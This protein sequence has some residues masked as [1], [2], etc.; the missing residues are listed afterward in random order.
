MSNSKNRDGNTVDGAIAPAGAGTVQ[1]TIAAL[2]ALGI[3]V[4][5]MGPDAS[6]SELPGPSGNESV[7]LSALA[8]LTGA[9]DDAGNPLVFSTSVAPSDLTT[10]I[11]DA[12]TT[13][14]TRPIDIR[15]A[16]SGLPSGLSFAATPAVV[17]DVAPGGS[18]D[19]TNGTD[20]ERRVDRRC[21][22]RQLR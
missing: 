13:A 7:F 4:L 19:F 5:G 21:V 22:H 6:P 18:A 11:V 2:N 10:S 3:R 20:E 16:A 12:L 1:G 15:L 9:V 8:R 14:A 17:D